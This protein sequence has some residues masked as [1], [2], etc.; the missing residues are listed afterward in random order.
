MCS[1]LET[2]V[3]EEEVTQEWWEGDTFVQDSWEWIVCRECGC[4][5]SIP[6]A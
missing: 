4:D 2:S 3:V 5:L 6:V 1:H